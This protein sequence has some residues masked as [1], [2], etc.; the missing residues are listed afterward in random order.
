MSGEKVLF[1]VVFSLDHFSSWTFFLGVRLQ[2]D[3]YYLNLTS[4]FTVKFLPG[5]LSRLLRRFKLQKTLKKRR[6]TE[7]FNDF[8]CILILA[9]FLRRRWHFF[10]RMRLMSRQMERM[11]RIFGKRNYYEWIRRSFRKH[12]LQSE[13]RGERERPQAA[14]APAVR[15]SS[16][17]ITVMA[18]L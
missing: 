3:I 6:E 12:C 7:H 15:W 14:Q 13:P 4:V 16:Y 1:T 9:V 11:W 2:T 18:E 10:Q 8:S 5:I 17:A